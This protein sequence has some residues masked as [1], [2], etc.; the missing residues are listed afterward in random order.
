[1]E[2]DATTVPSLVFSQLNE[3]V[4]DLLKTE[5]VDGNLKPGQRLSIRALADRLGASETPIRDALRRLN[6][7]GLVEMIPRRGTFVS[8]FSARTLQ[9]VYQIRRIIECASV[10]GLTETSHEVVQRMEEITD[11]MKSLREGEAFSDYQRYVALD[12]EFHQCLVGLLNNERLISFYETLC[13]PI[14]VVRSGAVSKYHRASATLAEHVALL[15]ALREKDISKA[16]DAI[17][18]HLREAEADLMR[19]LQSKRKAR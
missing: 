7:D 4:Y 10:D 12:V 2:L 19:R 11:E 15:K 3:Q 17:L 14:T 1:M 13:W 16:K 8:E 9:E 18:D 6:G 5:I